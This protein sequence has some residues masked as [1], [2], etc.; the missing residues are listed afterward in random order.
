MARKSSPERG[1][2]IIFDEMQGECSAIQEA[3]EIALRSVVVSDRYFIITG[4]ED[5]LE[6]RRQE[7][8]NKEN[9]MPPEKKTIA[10][11]LDRTLAQYGGWTG[12]EHIGEPHEGAK[13]FLRELS[14]NFRVLLWSTRISPGQGK[15]RMS[16]DQLIEIAESWLRFHGLDKYV[17]GLWTGVGKPIAAGFIDDRAIPC[18][19]QTDAH[20]YSTALDRA[21]ALADRSNRERQLQ[22]NLQKERS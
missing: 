10:V 18:D 19:P 12:P 7:R 14:K 1:S 11:D 5:I 3:K 20:A 21:E 4:R 2:L 16:H 13:E 6:E 17:D 8:T 22:E 15:N 9:A